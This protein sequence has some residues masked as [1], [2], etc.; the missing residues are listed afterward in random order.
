MRAL[1]RLGLALCLP[2]CLAASA[3][4]ES[5]DISGAK[6]ATLTYTDDA[7]AA[8]GEAMDSFKNK[9]WESAK[10]LF[11]EIRRLFNYSRYAR[12][13]EL[14]LADISFEQEKYSEAITA[15]REFG[16][17]HKNDPDTEYARY[18]MCKALF[19]DIDDT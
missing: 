2:L 17:S 8:Y 18:R 5:F 15:Y 11:G 14:R 1:R 6:H 9:D 3:G 13:A 10:A 16:Q 19:L 7:R 12:L 4:C